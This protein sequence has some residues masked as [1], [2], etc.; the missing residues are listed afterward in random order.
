MR[1]FCTRIIREKT[2]RDLLSFKKEVEK[3]LRKNLPMVADRTLKNKNITLSRGLVL[4]NSV[5]SDSKIEYK[6]DVRRNPIYAFYRAIIKGCV[7]MKKKK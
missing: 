5:L 2:Y 4:V 3:I 1:I 7:F 6:A